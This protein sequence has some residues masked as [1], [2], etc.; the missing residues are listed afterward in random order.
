MLRTLLLAA[1]ICC[2]TLRAEA[3][4]ASLTAKLRKG[5]NLSHWW[6]QPSRD[7]KAENLITPDDVKLIKTAGLTHVRVPIDPSTFVT[8]ED[9]LNQPAAARLLRTI[10]PFTDSGIAVVIDAHPSGTSAKSM[11]PAD[12]PEGWEAEATAFWKAFAPALKSTDPNLVAIELLN[13]PNG[14]TDPKAWPAAQERIRAVVRA[15]L[16]KHT[17]ILTGDDWA[18]I[19]GLV[20]LTP[21]SDTNVVYS[22]HFY[23]PHTFTHQGATW[24]SPMWKEIKDLRY[25]FDQPNADTALAATD[26]SKAINSIKAYTRDKWDA[27]KIKARFDKAKSWADEHRVTLYLGEFGAY[28]AGCD[29]QSRAAWTTDVRTA[30]EAAGIGWCAWDYAAGYAITDR[31]GKGPR[32]LNEPVAR[33]L[34]LTAPP[35]PK[36]STP[37]T[38]RKP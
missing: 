19:D 8:P 34:G 31:S 28:K 21:S 10:K 24:G 7:E 20:K 33:A 11:L 32:T 22:F 26:D 25:P 9:K 2:S 27:A 5:V 4:P 12:N 6:W 30:A 1:L 37:G 17:I 15:A 14:L 36:P 29:E 13:E 3:P 23:E 38:R 35:A 18:S 16:P